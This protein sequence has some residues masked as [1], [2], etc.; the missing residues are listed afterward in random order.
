AVSAAA[1]TRKNRPKVSPRTGQTPLRLRSSDAPRK[2]ASVLPS[3]RANRRSPMKPGAGQAFA[4]TTIPTVPAAAR[5]APARQSAD[6]PAAAGTTRESNP[7][8]N[9]LQ[10]C[11]QRQLAMRWIQTFL[12]AIAIC[13]PVWA[14][15]AMDKQIF[16]IIR[17]TAWRNPGQYAAKD[18]HQF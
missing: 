16:F 2:H 10:P 12:Q 11:L 8:Q 17:M 13:T 15:R 9:S 5:S 6:Q 4:Q 14:N 1:A 18:L 7:C 3:H